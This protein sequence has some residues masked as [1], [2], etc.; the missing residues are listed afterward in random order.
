MLEKLNEKIGLLHIVIL[1]EKSQIFELHFD[2]QT[3]KKVFTLNPKY[4]INHFRGTLT[5]QSLSK[6]RES[7]LRPSTTTIRPSVTTKMTDYK[8]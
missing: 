6:I 3:H 7:F 2:F 5:V 4:E 8:L 1:N